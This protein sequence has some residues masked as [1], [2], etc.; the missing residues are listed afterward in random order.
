MEIWEAINRFSIDKD[1]A[2]P[3][4]DLDLDNGECAICQHGVLHFQRL[5]TYHTLIL[6][7][8]ANTIWGLHASESSL[9]RCATGV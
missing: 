5:E 6:R 8:F 4:E 7:Q 3:F 1:G 2:S 9:I